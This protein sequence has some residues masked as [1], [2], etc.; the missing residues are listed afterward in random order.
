MVRVRTWV[1]GAVLRWERLAE[2]WGAE[3]WGGGWLLVREGKAWAILGLA[4]VPQG[5][6]ARFGARGWQCS[7]VI[8][9]QPL[10]IA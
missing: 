6:S 9:H 2:R 4:G 1:V 10:P 5:E 7:C 3:K 8:R